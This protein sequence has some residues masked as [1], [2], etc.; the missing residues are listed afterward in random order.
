MQNHLTYHLLGVIYYNTSTY[1]GEVLNA[2]L[3]TLHLKR[4]TNKAIEV[5]SGEVLSITPH[6][7]KS[8]LFM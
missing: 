5:M 8:M 7:R 6:Q 1:S 4:K 3:T 2:L